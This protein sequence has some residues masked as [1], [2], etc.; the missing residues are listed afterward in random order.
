MPEATEA[1]SARDRQLLGRLDAWLDLHYSDPGADVEGMA[2]A[3]HM[4]PRT[5]Q[6][7]LKSLTGQTPAAR[8][9]DVRL[10]RARDRLAAEDRSVTEIGLECGF[11]SAQYFSRVFRRQFGVA[12]DQWRRSARLG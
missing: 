7:K 9:R 11:A 12:P 6:R 4:S 1:V 10:E 5:L 2:A 3:V 8:L